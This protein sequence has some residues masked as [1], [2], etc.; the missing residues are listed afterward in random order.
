MGNRV[1]DDHSPPASLSRVYSP[2]PARG[3]MGPLGQGVALWVWLP[4]LPCL[5]RVP[6]APM[7]PKGN[8]TQRGTCRARGTPPASWGGG[9]IQPRRVGFVV[10]LLVITGKFTCDRLGLFAGLITSFSLPSNGVI[11]TCTCFFLEV[12]RIEELQDS[13]SS[14]RREEVGRRALREYGGFLPSFFY[15]ARFQLFE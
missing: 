2:P 14:P 9:E 3:A 10:N 13:N 15:R 1:G 5:R 6:M 12:R 8:P 7:A 4:W 11:Q